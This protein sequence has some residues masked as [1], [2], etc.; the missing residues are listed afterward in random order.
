MIVPVRMSKRMIA[1][2]LVSKRECVQRAAHRLALRIALWLT[3][4]VATLTG[5][6]FLISSL[7][8][9]LLESAGIW[10]AGLVTGAVVLLMALLI[11]V[12]IIFQPRRRQSVRPQQAAS[13]APTHEDSTVELSRMLANFDLRGTDA[14]IVALVSGVVLGMGAK[15]RRRRRTASSSD[16][17]RS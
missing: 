9:R 6:G 17:Q 13:P 15:Q 10:Q 7:Y 8:F 2:L 11:F 14:A 4:I 12:A 5:L 1:D 16:R 3:A